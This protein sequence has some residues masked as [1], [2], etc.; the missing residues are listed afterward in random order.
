MP[1]PVEALAGDLSNNASAGD[2]SKPNQLEPDNTESQS[3]VTP[4]EKSFEKPKD[5]IPDFNEKGEPCILRPCDGE[6]E[7]FALMSTD[8]VLEHIIKGKFKP[9]CAL[10]L[11]D[12]FI[13]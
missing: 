5:K 7:S 12:F 13:R 10:V 8:E 11:I 4:T 6:A 9:N 2:S 1:P 3:G